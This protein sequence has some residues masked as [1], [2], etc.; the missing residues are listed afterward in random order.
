MYPIIL[1]NTAGDMYCGD[2][3]ERRALTE[4]QNLPDEMRHTRAFLLLICDWVPNEAALTF[5]VA[6]RQEVCLYIQTCRSQEWC[7]A[8]S[9]GRPWPAVR[10]YIH[11]L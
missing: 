9:I 4:K 10:L 2:R 7:V 11:V 1:R 8:L 5:C 6:W 3:R